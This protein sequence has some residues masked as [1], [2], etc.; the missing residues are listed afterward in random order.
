[1]KLWIYTIGIINMGLDIVIRRAHGLAF[2]PESP[3]L[4]IHQGVST[5]CLNK[6]KRYL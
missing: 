2:S 1:M 6:I 5:F 3:E 4:P